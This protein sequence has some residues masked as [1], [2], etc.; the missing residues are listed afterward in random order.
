MTVGSY[1]IGF[2]TESNGMKSDGRRRKNYKVKVKHIDKSIAGC[3]KIVC[4]Y[5]TLYYIFAD[6]IKYMTI[7][8]VHTL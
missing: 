7:L 4:P 2:T 6:D 8:G 1:M 5:G 3:V